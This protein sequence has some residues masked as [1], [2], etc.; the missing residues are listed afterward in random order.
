MLS[1]FIYLKV[2]LAG[3]NKLYLLDDCFANCSYMVTNV[4]GVC[5]V[6]CA[7]ITIIAVRVVKETRKMEPKQKDEEEEEYWS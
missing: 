5:A 7:G 4:F 1:R 6:L 2:V 3:F